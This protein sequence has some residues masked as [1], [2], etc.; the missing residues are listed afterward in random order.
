MTFVYKH[1]VD[2]QGVERIEKTVVKSSEAPTQH[3]LDWKLR[4]NSQRTT[5]AK[6]RRV[7][8]EDIHDDFMREGWLP[9]AKFH[10]LLEGYREPCDPGPC[11]WQL[12]V[13]STETS[14]VCILLS[15]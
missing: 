10:G 7:R 9:E 8:L 3:I 2:D 13:V 12:A 5:R 14:C 15:G 11:Q 6:W 1:F 4:P